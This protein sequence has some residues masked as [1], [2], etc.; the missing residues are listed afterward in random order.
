MQTMSIQSECNVNQDCALSQICVQGICV[1]PGERCNSDVHC[2]KGETCQDTRCIDI[3][4][5]VEPEY[6]QDILIGGAVGLA[7]L[8]IIAILAVIF[9]YY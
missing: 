2:D 4:T 8:F 5:F 7:L 1:V 9:A 3:P 6:N